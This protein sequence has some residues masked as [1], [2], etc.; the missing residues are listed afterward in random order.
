MFKK[1]DEYESGL[2]REYR[3]YLILCEE[4]VAEHEFDESF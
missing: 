3:E 1:L 2:L 4:K